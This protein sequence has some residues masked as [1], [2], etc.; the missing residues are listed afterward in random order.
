LTR[1]QIAQRLLALLRPLAALMTVSALARVVN[2]GLGV[3]IPA[4]AAALVVGF[5][6]SSS[7]WGLLGVLALLALVKGTFRYVEQFTGH[8][9]AFQ[10]LSELRVDTYRNIVPLAPAGL[11]DERTGDLVARVIGDIDRVEPFYA[12]T[13]APLA[14]AVLVPLLTAVGLAVWVDPVVAVVFLPFPLVMVLVIPW[15]KAKRVAGTSSRARELAGETAA[16]FTD[17]VQGAREVAIFGAREVVAGRVSNRS[18]ESASIKSELARV[19]GTRAGLTDLLAGLAVVAVAAVAA[20]RFETGLIQLS[21]LAAAVV[22][23]WVGTTPARA[24]EDIVP[25][26]EQALAAAGRLFDLADRKAPVVERVD[27]PSSPANGIVVFEDVTVRFPDAD[28]PALDEV[29]AQ[30]SDGTFVAVVGPSGSGKSTLVELLARFRDPDVGRVLLGGTDLRDLSPSTR[31]ARIAFVP[32]RPEVFF[33]TIGDNLRLA[34]G[35]ATE[36]E[37]W[38]ALDRAGLGDWVRSLEHG[39]DTTTGELGET[40]SGG[41]RQ[42]LAIARAFLRRSDVLILDEAT[43]ELDLATERLVLDELKREHGERTVVVVAHR[44]EAVVDADE[45]L[46]L[47]GGRIVERGTHSTLTSGRGVYSGLWQRHTDILVETA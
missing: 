42:R 33:G 6:T 12:H 15:M 27:S 43:S 28:R 29:S 44:L 2:Q 16:V 3:L 17:S 30:L 24:L 45:I 14:S 32:Q 23:A 35:N 21:S 46:V 26:L 8:A 9:V 13:I 47:D 36:D 40:M 31:R 18:R 37:L 34:R 41:Q 1:S 39:L 4:L 22:V 38:G 25:D 20:G 11:E 5:A 19:A 10:L 7:V